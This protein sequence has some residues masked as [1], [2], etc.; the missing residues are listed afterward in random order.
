LGACA[1][2][3]ETVPAQPVAMRPSAHRIAPTQS[4]R[5]KSCFSSGRPPV[6]RASEKKPKQDPPKAV[7]Q[8][9]V[10]WVCSGKCLWLG[11]GNPT[12]RKAKI[13]SGGIA[14]RR[15]DR[16]HSPPANV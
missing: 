15:T 5:S 8:L 12:G 13:G 6:H 3:G 10:S 7:Q 14:Y 9:E 4:C 1:K 2:S 16:N 11:K